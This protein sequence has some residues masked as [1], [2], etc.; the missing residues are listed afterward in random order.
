VQ[1]KIFDPFDELAIERWRAAVPDRV[2]L[3]ADVFD[4]KSNGITHRMAVVFYDD[5]RTALPVADARDPAAEHRSG[6]I[7][8]CDERDGE[9]SAW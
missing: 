8:P 3:R 6:A 7:I 2:I 1:A 4:A 9:A 5:Y